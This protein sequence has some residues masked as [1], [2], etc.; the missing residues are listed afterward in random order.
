MM[1]DYDISAIK[2]TSNQRCYLPTDLTE[3]IFRSN[4]SELLAQ[5]SRRG[6][7]RGVQSILEQ[8]TPYV[9]SSWHPGFLHPGGRTEH[10]SDLKPQTYFFFLNT[11]FVSSHMYPENP[12]GTQVI[13]GSMNMG[14]ISDTARNRTHNL[15]RPKRQADIWQCLFVKAK[16]SANKYNDGYFV[17]RFCG[18]YKTEEKTNR[19]FFLAI[20]RRSY[21]DKFLAVFRTPARY[22]GRFGETTE[23]VEKSSGLDL[24]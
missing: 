3:K 1:I 7:H 8:C 10:T 22:K 20:Q 17:G 13:V 2:E 14:Y 21:V 15:F 23:F 4:S 9:E 18:L 5:Q 12:K 6:K 24:L 11:I 16:D 19:D